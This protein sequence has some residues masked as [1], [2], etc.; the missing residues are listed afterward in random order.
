MCFIPAGSILSYRVLIFNMRPNRGADRRRGLYKQAQFD[1]TVHGVRSSTLFWRVA[2]GQGAGR[3]QHR[4]SRRRS[5][6]E[7]CGQG[8]QGLPLIFVNAY[9]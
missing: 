4:D 8:Q 7:R 9:K 5:R 3:S 1:Y 6:R 2:P